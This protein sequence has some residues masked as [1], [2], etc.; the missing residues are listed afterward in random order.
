[1]FGIKAGGPTRLAIVDQ[2]GKMYERVA[3]ELKSDRRSRGQ[4]STEKPER[5]AG[6]LTTVPEN[7][8]NKTGNMMQ[9]SFRGRRNQTRMAGRL[10]KSARNWTR[11]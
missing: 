10:T 1:M 5:T 2:T 11:G 7:A 9:G 4:H 8:P 3:R 6:R